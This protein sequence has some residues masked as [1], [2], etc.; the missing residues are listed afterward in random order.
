MADTTRLHVP[1]SAIWDAVQFGKAVKNIK[2]SILQVK[3]HPFI[4]NIIT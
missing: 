4:T 1:V 3:K 2:D